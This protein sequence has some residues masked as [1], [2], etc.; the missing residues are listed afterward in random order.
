MLTQ[1]DALD[2]LDFLGGK[3]ALIKI[4]CQYIKEKIIKLRKS[5]IGF[6][7][8]SQKVKKKKG[9]SYQL[10]NPIFIGE[11]GISMFYVWVLSDVS[12]K[13]AYISITSTGKVWK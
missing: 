9:K 8:V 3:N 12:R 10:S 6:G 4:S 7:Q 5:E 2:D 11:L 13:A 1:D